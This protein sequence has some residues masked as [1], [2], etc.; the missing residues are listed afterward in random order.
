M[1]KIFPALCAM[2]LGACF[3]F[4]YLKDRAAPPDIDRVRSAVDRARS[5]F[6]NETNRDYR[7]ARLEL[8]SVEPIIGDQ[9]ALHLDLALIDLAEINYEVQGQYIATSEYR[10]FEHLLQSAQSRLERARALD[11]DSE[12]LAYNLARA[13]FKRAPHVDDSDQ[14]YRAAQSLLEPLTR[15][16]DPDASALMLYGDCREAFDEYEPAAAAYHAIVKKGKDHVPETLFRVSEY[17]F[18]SMLIRI[19]ERRQE[20]LALL[21]KFETKG[22]AKPGA[23]ERGRYTKF[24]DPVAPAVAV[25]DRRSVRWSLV[26]PRT[27]VPAL[28][29]NGYFLC[30][31]LDGDCVR[32][33]V[34]NSTGGMRILRN[35][36]N[37]TFDDQTE[38]ASLPKDFPLSAAAVGD[39]DNDGD[40]DLVVG[41]AK[42]LAIWMNDTDRDD[43]TRWIYD[44]YR[45][46]GD[47]AESM[48]SAVVCITLWDFDHD[49]DLD[50]FVG[51]PDGNAVY[52]SALEV[53][54]LGGRHLMYSEVGESL[55]LAQPPA[56]Q[57]VILDVDLDHDIDLLVG[58]V[59]GNVWFDNLR[60]LRFRKR[61]LPGTTPIIQVGDADND[62]TEEVL[63]S[64]VIYKYKDGA[65]QKLKDRAFLVDVDGDGI[66]DAH[67]F[68]DLPG[69]FK[70]MPVVA[71]LNRDGARDVVWRTE[72]GLQVYMALP[73]RPRA[74]LDF[75]P[76]GDRSNKAGIGTR[77]ELF[78]GDLRVGATV[79]DGMVSFG[80]GDRTVVHAINMLWTNG[81]EQ[82]RVLPPMNACVEVTERLG[83]IGSCPFLY[84]HDGKDWHFITDCHSGTPLGLPYADGKYLPPRSD[85]TV[86]VPGALLAPKDGNLRI[87]IAEEL[88]EITYLDR[89]RLRAIDHPA[90]TRAILNEG[91][92]V[93]SHP[94]F[95]VH[96]L[97]DLRPPRSAR[98]HRGRDLLARVA[99]L[100]RKHAVVFESHPPMYE[101]LAK[102]W[103]IELDF[104]DVSGAERILF[105][106]DGWIEFPSASSSIAASQ[107]KSVKFMPP[108]L[109]VLGENG[110]WAVAV[111]EPGFPAGKGKSVLVDMTGKFPTKN[112]RIR[113]RSTLK[114]H[115]DGF[116]LAT[117]ADQPMRLTELPLTKATH[118]YRGMGRPILDPT[119]ELWWR[120]DH[121]DLVDYQRWGQWPPGMLTAYGD[122]LDLVRET[123]SRYPTVAAGDVVELTFDAGALPPL[124]DGWV[125]DW[126]VTTRGWV[127]DADMNQAVRETVGPLPFHGMSAYPYPDAEKHPHEEFQSKW[128][129]RPAREVDNEKVLIETA[130]ARLRK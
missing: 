44:P 122:V 72:S 119:G 94:E 31:D 88:R 33:L 42:G 19:P 106:M 37:A 71:D 90:G 49:N 9:P 12:A 25:A 39:L 113:L 1:K 103:A 74:W 100:D 89:V 93:M 97:R 8:L 14:M 128:F 41:G 116:F 82:G 30:A 76:I 96:A 101:G 10:R 32:D 86:F 69:E 26:T 29:D 27:G 46:M 98:D 7:R 102:E 78:A 87:D 91:F 112:G 121:D 62:L 50:L 67:P 77:V 124:K 126:C 5:F 120:Y 107:T 59:S 35:R 64:G 56:H 85:E 48:K 3:A 110:E 66:L 18:A 58:S 40:L 21:E 75:K 57:A 47:V 118:R 36:R 52:R 24:L 105:V 99:K 79:R 73:D 22:R 13:Y 68:Q 55:G 108:V 84:T 127:K 28:D 115:W 104:G 38:A 80:L 83:E 70:G 17:R 34:M 23:L 11:P 16:A 81:V 53:S 114:I 130:R 123:D 51:G 129:T 92:R 63:L 45:P 6:L 4:I 95:R 61:D 65:F 111:A 15:L 20:G 60:E 43:P 109:E 117:G 2:I 125:R 54:A